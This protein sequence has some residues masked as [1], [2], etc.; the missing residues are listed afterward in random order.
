MILCRVFIQRSQLQV[1]TYPSRLSASIKSTGT[2]NNS[3]VCLKF[4]MSYRIKFI[5]VFNA[6]FSLME[7]TLNRRDRSIWLDCR[8]VYLSFST[9]T[10]PF[11][12]PTPLNM[13]K[14]KSLS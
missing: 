4:I 10:F 11:V 14:T 6:N 3:F 12:L 7:L 9:S 2:N 8:R 5:K 1:V 13:L